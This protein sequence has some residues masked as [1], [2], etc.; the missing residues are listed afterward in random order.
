MRHGMRGR[1]FSR[2]T[3]ARKALLKNLATA[4]LKHEQVMTTL[5]KAR[6]VR[7]IVEKLIT[8]GK[9]GDLHA[10]RHA[11]AMVLEKAVVDKL[12]SDLAD[13]YKERQGG[14]TRVLKNGF[15]IGDA[16]PMGVVELIERDVGAK[17]TDSGPTAEQSDSEQ[18]TA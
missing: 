9:R 1:K 8:L 12:F 16:S 18:A 10:R 6:E 13:R 2:H 3:S 14:Y 7:P 15:R 11:L 4:V 5:P 17:G